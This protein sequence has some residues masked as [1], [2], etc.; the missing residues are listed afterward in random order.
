MEEVRNK[1][2]DIPSIDRLLL[3]AQNDK[4]FA[5]FGRGA[6][7]DLLRKTVEEVRRQLQDGRDIDIAPKTLLNNAK[8]LLRNIEQPSL[9]RVIN[10]TGIVLHTNLGRAP[11]GT[12]A[13][14]CVEQA[15]DGYCTLEYDIATGGR[16]SRYAHVAGKICA[17]TGAEDALCVNNNAAAVLLV[18]SALAK[19]REVIVSRGELVEIGGSFRVP[20][21]LLQSGATLTEVGTTN[22]THLSDYSKAIN[23]NTAMI[24]KV[25]TSN[26]RITGFTSQPE[27][28][29]LVALAHQYGIPIVEDLG[30]GML[31]PVKSAGQGE[32]TVADQLTSGMDIVTFSG[33]KLLGGGQAGII[34]GKR[35]YVQTMK[36]HP[37][38]RAIRLDKLSLAALE[39]TLIDYMVARPDKAIPVQGMLKATAQDLKPVAEEL[40]GMLEVLKQNNWQIEVVKIKSQ[41]GGGSLPGVDFDSYGVSVACK[42]FS[43]AALEKML[44]LWQTPII[45]RIQ[46][47]KIIFDVRCLVPEDI[48]VICQA[49]MALGRGDKR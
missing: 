28:A 11:L 19:G 24:L 3:E 48:V 47:E 2:R 31:V 44:R 25:H 36:N 49:C 38:L 27:N 20:D 10:A 26:Y 18:L 8:E 1:L 16:G 39:G 5:A 33:D 45:T 15:M 42:Q 13:R 12:R 9:R 46:E 4:E 41:A 6:I 23:A 37:L 17:I 14:A 40:A 32:P 30:S 7:A 43:A 34:A 29:D 35:E 22:R 21:V